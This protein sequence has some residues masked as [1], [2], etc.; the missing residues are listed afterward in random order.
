MFKGGRSSSADLP[1]SFVVRAGNAAVI[2]SL[3][4]ALQA[5]PGVDEVRVSAES[6][7]GEAL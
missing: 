2:E 1:E 5:A 4:L 7:A 6:A 3:V